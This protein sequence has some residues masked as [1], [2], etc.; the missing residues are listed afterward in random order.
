MKTWI[1]LWKHLLALQT[2]LWQLVGG[3]DYD[4]YA[5]VAAKRSV[6][7]GAVFHTNSLD[8]CC[9]ELLPAL[10]PAWTHGFTAARMALLWVSH[11][12]SQA[13][14]LWSE[15]RQLHFCSRWGFPEAGYSCTVST[16]AV[17]PARQSG[18]RAIREHTWLF[19]G[20][21]ESLADSVAHSSC[22][23]IEGTI[24]SLWTPSPHPYF[25]WQE[26]LNTNLCF[27]C[28]IQSPLSV[29]ALLLLDY[30]RDFGFF[31]L[32]IGT[33]YLILCWENYTEIIHIIF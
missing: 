25:Y 29:P 5:D 4:T 19:P 24:I 8:F 16:L 3:G 10:S 26:S 27:E 18:C 31:F 33:A 1:L 22:S 12:L 21:F 14:A 13:P 7:S 2:E 30:A 28:P 9:T 32:A 11:L 17:S 15:Q 23:W 20:H 6:G